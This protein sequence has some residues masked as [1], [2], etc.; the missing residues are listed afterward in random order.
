MEGP[1]A[2]EK[3]FSDI[4]RVFSEY[5]DFLLTGLQNTLKSDRSHV[6]L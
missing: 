2:F 5:N 3:F 4:G 6:V 1:S